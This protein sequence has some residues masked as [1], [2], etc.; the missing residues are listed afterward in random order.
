LLAALAALSVGLSGGATF[1]AEE[2]EPGV[3]PAELLKRVPPRYPAKAVEHGEEGWVDLRFTVT[4]EGTTSDVRVVGAYPRGVFERSAINA[5][6]KWIYAPRK[7]NAAPVP[8]SNNRIVLSFALS[9]RHAIRPEFAPAFDAA[10][11]AINNE[12]WDDAAKAVSDIAKSRALSLYESAVLEELRGRLHFAQG[13]FNAAADCFGRA[14]AAN[15][16]LSPDDRTEMTEL[17][18]M[19]SLNGRDYARGVQAFD[20]WNPPQGWSNR[21][22]RRAVETARGAVVT[23]RPVDLPRLGPDDE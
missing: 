12:K 14:L 5:V 4:P 22:L 13:R 7:E 1:A 9:D 15:S 11:D 20:H 6:G 23:G 3:V 16:H 19:S 2:G 17:L 21:S 18:V 10:T 8:Q